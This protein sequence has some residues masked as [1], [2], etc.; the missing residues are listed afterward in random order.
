MYK[1]QT[2]DRFD[3]L[4]RDFHRVLYARS[5]N[6]GLWRMMRT[7]STHLDR[8]RRLNLP[9]PGKM[10]AVLEDH[11]AIVR[12]VEAANR[13]GEAEQAMRRHLS[14]TLAMVD[15]ISDRYPEFVLRDDEG[16]VVRRAEPGRVAAG[17]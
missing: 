11:R 16:A 1:R 13:S 5:G 6:L 3:A 8:L 9:M 14:G 2:H 12:A 4:D 7:R 10:Q 17:L 15:A